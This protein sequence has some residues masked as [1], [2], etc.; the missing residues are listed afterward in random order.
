MQE[1]WKDIKDYEGFYQVSNKGRI[2]SVDREVK[3]GFG[4][5]RIVKGRIMKTDLSNSGYLRVCGCKENK[6]FKIEVHRAVIEAFIPNPKNKPECNHK[7]GIKTNNHVDNLEWATRSENQRHAFDNGLK[8]IPKGSNHHNT[9]LTE[10]DVRDIKKHLKDGLTQQT[11]AD[12]Y[13]VHSSTISNINTKKNWA[14][15]T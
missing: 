13:G 8:N 2:K 15:V 4:S 10:D 3:A 7:D 11:I 14:H 9:S 6:K 5:T 12:F 1:E